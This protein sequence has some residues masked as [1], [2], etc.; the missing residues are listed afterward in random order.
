MNNYDV[1]DQQLRGILKTD[2][3]DHSILFHINHRS[4]QNSMG[5][6][7]EL[8]GIMNIAR[9]IQYVSRIQNIDWRPLEPSRH[10]QNIRQNS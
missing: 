3:S 7:Y 5:N 2:I 9:T 10:C 4:F 8:I 1:K 6:E